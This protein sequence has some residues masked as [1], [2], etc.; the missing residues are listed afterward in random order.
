MIYSFYSL[1]ILP[2]WEAV[3]TGTIS[4][5][6][7]TNEPNGLILF[8]MGAKPPRV[9]CTVRGEAFGV[10]PSPQKRSLRRSLLSESLS[11][12]SLSGNSRSSKL[13]PE[14]SSSISLPLKCFIRDCEIR[15]SLISFETFIMLH[16]ISIFYVTNSSKTLKMCMRKKMEALLYRI[17]K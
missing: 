8:N 17:V 15:L 4:F 2:K 6:F 14:A 7:R 10:G 5:K 12:T 9:G 1:Q 3:K 16:P 13:S 11:L